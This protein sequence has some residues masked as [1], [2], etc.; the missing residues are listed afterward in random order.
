MSVHK[1]AE[2]LTCAPITNVWILQLCNREHEKPTSFEKHAQT[3]KH[4]G[5]MTHSPLARSLTLHD[6]RST[7][8]RSHSWNRRY[9]RYQRDL[10]ML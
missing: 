2:F 6:T 4:P 8:V 9:Q 3:R 10:P 7:Q 1:S 5:A